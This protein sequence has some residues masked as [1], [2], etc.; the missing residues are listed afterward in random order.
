MM[1]SSVSTA[2]KGQLC[3]IE[4]KALGLLEAAVKPGKFLTYK[5]AVGELQRLRVDRKTAMR[6][7]ALF[8][9]KG[10]LKASLGHG[11]KLNGRGEEE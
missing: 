7:L 6:V 2:Y 8:A 4:A 3:P 11:V 5:E 9:R 1:A 10:I